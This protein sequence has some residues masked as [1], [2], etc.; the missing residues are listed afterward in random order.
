MEKKMETTIGVIR[1]IHGYPLFMFR[2]ECSISSPLTG[3]PKGGLAPQ[4]RFWAQGLGF[5]VRGPEFRVQGLGFR[6]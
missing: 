3:T 2:T 1:G 6:V 4:L 5:R